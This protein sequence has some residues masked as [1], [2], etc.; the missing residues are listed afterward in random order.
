MDDLVVE[1]RNAVRDAGTMLN[2]SFPAGPRVESVDTDAAFEVHYVWDYLARAHG[3]GE[4]VEHMPG[5]ITILVTWSSVLI[6]PPAAASCPGCVA[7]RWSRL[8][9]QSER[10]VLSELDSVMATGQG[11]ILAPGFDSL[12]QFVL[13][14]TRDSVEHPVVRRIDYLTGKWDEYPVLPDPI[15]GVN[16]E[17]SRMPAT[18]AELIP[19]PKRHN[20]DF[21]RHSLHELSFDLAPLLN[22]VSGVIG[23]GAINRVDFTTTALVLGG[24][25]VRVED[26]D[27]ELNWSGQNSS[28]EAS[29]SAGIIEGLERYAGS[30][31]RNGSTALR[32]SRN[33]LISPSV[34]PGPAVRYSPDFLAGSPWV[35]SYSDDLVCEWVEGYD[36]TASQTTLVPQQLAFYYSRSR[37]DSRFTIETSSGCA[38]GGTV[39][40]AVLFGLCELVERDAF[41]LGW[42][43][44]AQLRE[45]YPDQAIGAKV[46]Q[47]LS[48]A[49][50]LGFTIRLFDNRI[51]LSVPVVTAV[52]ERVTGSPEGEVVFAAAASFDPSEACSAALDEVMTYIAQR[53]SVSETRTSQIASMADDF[54]QVTDLRDHADLYSS[55]K[56]RKYLA[57]Y[58]GGGPGRPFSDVYETWN[59]TRPVTSDIR[60]D[61]AHIVDKLAE[62]G[63]SVSYVEQTTPEQASLGL[64]CV[65]VIA[66]GLV[67]IDFG[68][69]H[70]RV[71]TMPRL[72]SAFE[73][74]EMKPC[75]L[76][77]APHPFP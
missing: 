61:I 57:G 68:W 9:L 64:A 63:I 65:A 15:C 6:C 3:S 54:T 60:D 31:P 35:T 26:Q 45:I 14:I 46:R 44:G 40:E 27:V 66:P 71:L 75:Q 34:D 7:E 72:A 21:R 13:A 52:A 59:A 77:M 19:Q 25:N 74:T 56:M 22:P 51:D 20:D 76:R 12:L 16:H 36:L 67:P 50:L 17:R 49:A 5:T 1:I 62:R 4:Q 28:Y 30:L 10:A 18:N 11:P 29:T 73:G 23:A 58:L 37:A 70:Q 32:A 39:T 48:R 2:V 47:A 38:S 24:V 69:S 43:S 8:R 55:P 33:E 41:L 53:S 42:Y